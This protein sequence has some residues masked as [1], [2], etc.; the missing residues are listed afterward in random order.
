M[1]AAV[2]SVLVRRDRQA[3]AG[4]GRR[5][6][7]SRMVEMG[8]DGVPGVHPGPIRSRMLLQGGVETPQGVR[9]QDDGCA[10][11]AVSAGSGFGIGHGI[12]LSVRGSQGVDRHRAALVTPPVPPSYTAGERLTKRQDAPCPK[13]ARPAK[14]LAEARG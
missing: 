4:A 12:R 5:D 2:A 10:Q 6:L 3:E 9:E 1:S 11:V 7:R 8:S 13:A 14:A